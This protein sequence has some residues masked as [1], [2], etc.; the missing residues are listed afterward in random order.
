MRWLLLGTLLLLGGCGPEKSV[1][2]GYV[3]AVY[4]EFSSPVSG[5]LVHRPRNEGVKVAKGDHVFSLSESP[6]KEKLQGIEAEIE[7]ATWQLRDLEKGLRVD[8]LAYLQANVD[9]ALAD[10]HYWE[11]NLDR[12]ELLSESSRSLDELDQ[13]RKNLQKAKSAF[14]A[15]KA[16]LKSGKMGERSDLVLAK[17]AE[18]KAL[19]AKKQ[20]LKWYLNQKKILVGFDGRVK[21]IY[22]EKGEWVKA[23]S[24]ILTIENM[25]KRHVIFYLTQF[26]L[27]RIAMGDI[28]EVQSASKGKVEAR[29]IYISDNA[30]FTP[31]IVYTTQQGDLYCFKV[32]AE[33]RSTTYIHPGQPV[34]IKL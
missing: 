12:L 9:S 31:P 8:D 17:R 26:E 14:E 24:P 13:A 23:Y 7:R 21:E 19:A 5:R 28:V 34:T 2:P 29:I 6:E 25:Q 16:K 10:V 20:E 27:D 32:K 15:S 22:Y 18:L 30:E 1:V 3:E 11:Q 4:V 33:L